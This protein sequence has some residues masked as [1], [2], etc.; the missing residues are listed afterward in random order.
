MSDLI[1]F[2]NPEFDPSSHTIRDLVK[3]LSSYDV[4]LPIN[5]AKKS[6]YVELT[7]EYLP[8]LRSRYLADLKKSSKKAPKNHPFATPM[9]SSVAESPRNTP[10]KPALVHSPAIFT[11][12]NP[13]QS[14]VA[15]TKPSRKSSTPA[16]PLQ[17]KEKENL[18]PTASDPNQ[19][20]TIHDFDLSRSNTNSPSFSTP[21]KT[22]RTQ[23][24]SK[25]IPKT[26]GLETSSVSDG[27]GTSSVEFVS[28]NSQIKTESKS[29]PSTPLRL[30]EPFKSPFK[31][32]FTS[33]LPKKSIL[34]Q[35]KPYSKPFNF[36]QLF[37][38][39]LFVLFSVGLVHWSI[40]DYP[41]LKYCNSSQSNPA[42]TYP[43]T[44]K[45]IPCPSNS[46]CHDK[47]LSDCVGD[48]FILK[49]NVLFKYLPFPFNQPTCE[50]DATKLAQQ[51]KKQ[52]QVD[53]LVFVLD[54][55]VREYIG[56]VQCSHSYA[57]KQPK[58]I[59]STTKPIKIIGMPIIHAKETLHTLVGD[60]WTNDEFQEYWNLVMK[61][62]MNESNLPITNIVDEQ[63]FQHRLLSSQNQSIM[64]VTCKLRLSFWNLIIAY[65]K[66]LIVTGF[67]LA[68]S[69]LFFMYYQQSVTETEMV[70]SLVRDVC[71]LIHAEAENYNRD[72]T[73]HP[74]P[75]FPLQHLQDHFLPHTIN[76]KTSSETDANGYTLFH[77]PIDA[78]QRVWKRVCTL[79]QRNSRIRETINQYQ[80]ETQT[81][82]VWVGSSALS[83]S[84]KRDQPRI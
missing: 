37:S 48:D 31:A 56:K 1:D 69:I 77:L 10:S 72:A 59:Y 11:D 82:W 9:K 35:T 33:S 16:K 71:S 43:M 60:Q 57:S 70:A 6:T 13:F 75:G 29:S 3:L 19:R 32:P 68:I 21:S 7:L 18:T 40:V 54:Q 20:E 5:G 74:I 41:L 55:L 83:P 8:Y 80:G 84:K 27:S 39:A 2:I 17:F 49:P 45:C 42:M 76:P 36:S 14:P 62:I 63:T 38:G 30:V 23:S 73:H 64:N 28:E 61:K 26:N 34:K 22:T 47:T 65:S 52:K 53:H 51:S 81:I 67:V 58:W 44:P 25:N 50:L 79:I 46:V 15:A 66:E 4:E 24:K 12:D 78:R